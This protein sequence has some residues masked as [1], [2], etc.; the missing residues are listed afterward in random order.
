MLPSVNDF[1]VALARGSPRV[2][3]RW[4]PRYTSAVHSS[5]PSLYR[6]QLLGAALALLALCICCSAVH[7][8]TESVE[9]LHRTGPPLTALR[10]KIADPNWLVA[11]LLEPA[12]PPRRPFVHDLSLGREEALIVSRYLYSGAASV[13]GRVIWHG[14]DARKGERLFV[15]R[16]CRACHAIGS[17]ES[18]PF[19]RA[20]NLVGIGLKVRGAWLFRWL[21]SPRT[22]DPDTAMPQLGLSDDDIRH[23]VAFLLSHREGG[24]VVAAA[25]PYGPQV[26]T[27]S[28]AYVI[29]RFGCVKCHLINGFHPVVPKHGWA[30]APRSCDKCHEVSATLQPASDEPRAADETDAALRDGRRLVAYYGCRGCHR[31]EGKGG[32]IADFVERKT[33]VPPT[34]DGEGARVQP[35]W[36]TECLRHPKPLRPWMQLRNPNF[37]LSAAEASALTRY[38]AALAHVPATDEALPSTGPTVVALGQRR[39]AHFK[40]LQCHPP[41]GQ[42]PPSPDIDPEDLAISLAITKVRL[43]PSWVREFLAWPKL[44]VGPETRMP[45]VFYTTDGIPNVEHPE[46]DIDAITAYLYEVS[47]A[48]LGK[49]PGQDRHRRRSSALPVHHYPMESKGDDTR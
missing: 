22:Y 32:V 40:C 43:R 39:F 35:S 28:A 14:G 2:D 37:D 47:D 48:S 4:R 3:P 6:N 17:T 19:S 46:R 34:L 10:C 15:S 45:A 18:V 20:P 27:D 49:G 7:A 33:F 36:L 42:T 30:A 9:D 21:K 13:G 16:G 23:L 31:I 41:N 29:D 25:P 26:S 44:V 24:K 12:H 1:A 8:Q 5:S 38:F 11:W